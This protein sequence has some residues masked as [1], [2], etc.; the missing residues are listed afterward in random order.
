[1]VTQG[2]DSF[3]DYFHSLF[4][5]EK[6]EPKKTQFVK[7]VKKTEEYIKVNNYIDETLNSSNHPKLRK[8]AEVLRTFFSDSKHKDKSNVIVFV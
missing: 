6:K 4:D 3:K 8:L 5:T 7:C 1:L 2:T